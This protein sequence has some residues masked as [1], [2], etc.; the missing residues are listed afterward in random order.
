M[1]DLWYPQ[2]ADWLRAAGLTVHETDGWETRAR[3]SGGFNAPPLGVQWHHTAGNMN[4]DA[5]LEWQTTGSEDA[6][7]GNMLLWDDGAIYMVA[8]G[9]ANTA[10]KGGPVTMSRGTVPKDSGNS[11]TWA[12][13]AANNG[14]GQPWPQAQVDAYFVASNTLNAHFGNVAA[15]VF[16]HKSYC[17]AS[18]PGR[19]VDPATA[20][21]ILGPWRPRADGSSGTWHID[22]V[23]AEATRRATTH[24]P[25]PEPEP[26]PEPVPEDDDMLF[27]CKVGSVYYVGNGARAV[28][29]AGDDVDTLKANMEGAG[30][31]RWRHPARSGLPVL[32]R[33]ADVPAINTGQRRILV[34]LVPG[35]T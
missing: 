27:V 35:E 32:T 6:P 3:S 15:D 23:H 30:S 5:N 4:L 26:E 17:D 22:D 34:G 31:A 19:K 24:P 8:A 13:E 28:P 9:A 7:I 1:G 12:I 10:G 14:S 29:V 25:E 18:C 20:A 21:A 33:L 2:A 16:T 11:T